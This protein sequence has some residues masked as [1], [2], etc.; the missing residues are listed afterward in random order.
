MERYKI[1]IK[2]R[3]GLY[4]GMHNKL[5]KTKTFFEKNKV[6]FLFICLQVIVLIFLIIGLFLERN[7]LE[8]QLKNE[9]GEFGYQENL[10][11]Q[12]KSKTFRSDNY[13]ILPGAYK[14]FVK[15]SSEK[16]VNNPSY[17]LKDT[18]ATITFVSSSNPS[19]ISMD[20]IVL[21]DGHKN[22]DGRLWIHTFPQ[23]K[24]FAMEMTYHG[25]G[26]ISV[27][28]VVLRE[29][30]VYRFVRI[31]KFVLVAALFNFLYLMFGAKG[32]ELPIHRKKAI[33]ALMAITLIASLP[34][35]ADFIFR[36][37]DISFHMQRIVAVAEE[38]EHRQVPVRIMSNMLNGYGY[39]NSLFYCDI[40]LY[41][42]AILYNLMLPLRTCYQIYL[43]LV[44]LI[45]CLIS[46]FVFS[47][48][49]NSRE[50]GLVGT[51]IYV[52]SSYRFINVY[53]RAAVGEYTA[54]CFLPLVIY[55]M[56]RIYG[57]E[58]PGWRD[59]LPLSVAMSGIIHC[60]ILTVEMVVL[61][62]FLYVL[63]NIKKTLVWDRFFALMKAAVVALGISA[64]FVLPFLD[65][66][67]H[68]PVN[69]SERIN[70]IQN[71]G[72][73]PVQVFGL[74]LHGNGLNVRGGMSGEMPLAIGITYVVGIAIA[75]YICLKRNVWKLEGNPH[76]KLLRVSFLYG[77]LALVLTLECVPYNNIQ[78]MFGV[79]S[80]KIVGVVQFSWRY[81]SV[82][83]IL[84]AIMIVMALSILKKMK[85]QAY[86]IGIGCLIGSQ[87]LFTG[88]F[89]WQ[90]TYAVDESAFHFG[91]REQTMKIGKEEYLP[92][93]AQKGPLYVAN[94]EIVE[95][96]AIINDY[97]RLNGKVRIN[98]KN[99]GGVQAKIL[100]PVL[101]YDNYHIQDMETGVENLIE[102]GDNGRIQISLAPGYEGI[103]E[104]E[105]V[106]PFMW[107]V[108]ELL[109]L[110]VILSII[111]FAC[112]F[113]FLR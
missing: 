52:F 109:S 96:D 43:F 32:I 1:M 61:F 25:K 55:G 72:L 49:T 22:A 12:R 20:E 112:K 98:C 41:L 83:T 77:M 108:A 27:E 80:A 42:P 18:T 111:A 14:V 17:S 46:Y 7:V 15:Y 53:V 69:V 75:S 2:D 79:L 54:M 13:N 107:R 106:P 97:Q 8:V 40:F 104:L 11:D 86:K 99:A 35:F 21:D 90:Y 67:L 103:L 84:F 78:N 87:I 28:S 26:I 76:Y 50:L 30:I 73:Y 64:W 23:L 6:F 60:H 31:V 89:Y 47:K 100:L 81:L 33:F 95:G 94:C 91:T 102:T 58:K 63:F 71:T 113:W 44:T 101:N 85:S 70:K 56:W 92:E 29:Q 5:M 34:V 38:L 57:K 62:L 66:M 39:A 10:T 110:I 48:M 37:H 65:S 16:S 82:V 45:T 36:G 24:D 3:K 19:A 88:I 9:E 68:M 4:K 51:I 105:Y 93:F 74:F 59:W